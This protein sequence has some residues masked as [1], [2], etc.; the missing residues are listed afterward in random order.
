MRK[1]G[2]CPSSPVCGATSLEEAL[3]RIAVRGIDMEL[4]IKHH[5]EQEAAGIPR[6]PDLDDD[7]PF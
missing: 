2:R 4:Q 7:I 6:S 5:D 3:R 1:P